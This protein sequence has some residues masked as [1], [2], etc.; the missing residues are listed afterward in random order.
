[1]VILHVAVMEMCVEPLGNS[2]PGGQEPVAVLVGQSVGGVLVGSMRVVVP[3]ALIGGGDEGLDRPRRR[4]GP[5]PDVVLTNTVAM[6]DQ[7]LRSL[8]TPGGTRWSTQSSRS[9]RLSR[10]MPGEQ[11]YGGEDQPSTTDKKCG[12]QQ[13]A[14]GWVGRCWYEVRVR[15]IT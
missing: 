1:M 3:T 9:T 14:L 5:A 15:G 7:A 4:A 13:T 8:S 2:E 11:T 6:W 12:R 10:P